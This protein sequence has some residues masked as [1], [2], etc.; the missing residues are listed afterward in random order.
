VVGRA[1]RAVVV[2]S[3]L[4]RLLIRCASDSDPLRAHRSTGPLVARG[5]FERALENTVLRA[6]RQVI[7]ASPLFLCPRLPC[8]V[9]MNLLRYGLSCLKRLLR[10]EPSL[11]CFLELRMHSES[12]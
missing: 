3:I 9:S 12:G 4:V 11:P 1:P 8:R 7:L 10:R 6:S 5:R 2:R